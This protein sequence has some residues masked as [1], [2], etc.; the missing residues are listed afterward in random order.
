MAGVKLENLTKKYSKK[1]AAVDNIDLEI[2]D[3]EFMVLLGP[4]GCGKTTTLRCIAGL[5]TPTSGKIY[6]GDTLVNDIPEKERDTAMVFQTFAIFPHM[7]VYDN[8]AFPLKMRKVRTKDGRKRKLP[9]PEI[10]KAVQKTAELLKISHLLDRMP[11]QLSGGQRQRVA[12]VR[13]LICKPSVVLADEPTGS[14]D[15][16]AA[17]QVAELLVT[18]NQ[19]HGATLIVATHA[20]RLAE[21]MGRRFR[22]EHKRLM[23]DK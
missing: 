22:L 1:V 9:K 14:L 21:R 7:N 13:A 17:E 2:K 3:K 11:G 5:E 4:S 15:A 23:I 19:T 16:D 6:I 20:M 12:L 8:I 18:L 10:K